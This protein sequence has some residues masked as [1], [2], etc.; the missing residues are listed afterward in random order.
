MIEK[1]IALLDHNVIVTCID[2][3][4][5]HGKWIDCLDAED[6]SDE[7]RQEDSILVEHGE[8][9]TEIYESDIK[10]IQDEA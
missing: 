10:N 2:G 6:A 9:L 8:F 4:T 7:E 1:H 5:I 3:K